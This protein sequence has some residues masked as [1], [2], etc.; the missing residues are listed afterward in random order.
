MPGPDGRPLE[1]V[2]ARVVRAGE[3]PVREQHAEQRNEDRAEQQQEALVAAHV[4]RECAGGRERPSA[5]TISARCGTRGR[6]FCV[7]TAAEYTFANASSVS[8]TV[9]ASSASAAATPPP[10]IAI[11][12]SSGWLGSTPRDSTRIE[13]KPN[14]NSVGS[15]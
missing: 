5:P 3:Q 7:E 10:A 15:R 1:D 6:R 12:I 2:R 8:S 14:W 9:S 4:D 13:P 11:R